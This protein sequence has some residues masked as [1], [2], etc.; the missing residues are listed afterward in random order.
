MRSPPRLGRGL[1]SLLPQTDHASFSSSEVTVQPLH[2]LEPGPF[3]PR[4][5]LKPEDLADLAS[6]I[7]AQGVLQPILVRPHPSRTGSF[8]IVAGERRWRAAQIAGLAT[9]PC[10]AREMT[11]PEAGAAALIENL[12][13]QDLNPIE[14]AEGFQRLIQSFGLTQEALGSAIGKSRSHIANTLRLL[15]LPDSVRAH[16]QSGT[17]TAGHARAAMACIDPAAA[18]ELMV[19]KGLTVRQAEA[20]SSSKQTLASARQAT[21]AT[22]PANA[23]LRAVETDLSEQL[24]LQVSIT[25]NGRGG[26]IS[27]RYQNLDQLDHIVARLGRSHTPQTDPEQNKR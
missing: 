9:I 4:S 25:F 13:R 15:S 26:M 24:G 21:P 3:Q 17:L 14:E 20:L 8:Q 5:P 22:E 2:L 19:T 18:A 10:F 7:K 27:L 23:D 11:D 12:Q 16:V 1:T 6:S